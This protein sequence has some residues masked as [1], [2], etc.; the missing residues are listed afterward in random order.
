MPRTT[1]GNLVRSSANKWPIGVVRLVLALAAISV[2]L[3]AQ[4]L[5]GTFA[6]LAPDHSGTLVPSA[7]VVLTNEDTG[8]KL[9]RS[10]NDSGN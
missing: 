9:D 7:R 10:T 6:G 8:A 5:L 4:S 2:P 3:F 1:T